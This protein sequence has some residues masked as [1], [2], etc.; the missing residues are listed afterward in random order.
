MPDGAYPELLLS[1]VMLCTSAIV[2]GKTDSLYVS[3]TDANST[4]LPL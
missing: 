3:E 2:P 1:Q 4:L